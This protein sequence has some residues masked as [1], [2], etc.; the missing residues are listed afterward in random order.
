[1]SEEKGYKNDTSEEFKPTSGSSSENTSTISLS[2]YTTI[3]DY[4][5]PGWD[6]SEKK[7]EYW[8]GVYEKAKYEGRHRYDPSYKWT[9][10]EEKRLVRKIDLRIMLWAWIMFC[11]LDLNRR[12]IN[13]AITDNMLPELGMTTNDFNYG[14]TIFLASFLAAELPSGLIS[15]KLGPD[16]WIPFIIVAWSVVSASQGGIHSR[17]AYFACR[18]LMGLFMGGFVPD[19]VLYLT[20]FYKSR[21]LPIRLSWFWTGISTS[22][23]LGSFLAA[24][25]L[26]MRG[27][28][29]LSGWRYL[30][31]LEGCATGIIGL[32]SWGF[33][34][35]GPC[36]T[37]GNIMRNNRRGWF[38]EH[39]EYILVNRLLRDDPSKGDL[40]NRAAVG[41]SL[42]WKALKDYD[43][44]PV[45]LL[46][47]TAYVP[48]QPVA[49]YLSFILRQL[50][51]S[52]FEANLL[53]IPG[54]FLYAAQLVLITWVSERFDERSLIAS[55]S[56]WWIFPFLTA[57][58]ALKGTASLWVRYTLLTGIIGYPYCHAILAG[59][60]SRNSN[61]VR[62][63]TIS[64][65][66]YNMMVQSGNIIG[67]NIYRE[68]DKPLY[69]R[70]NK[71]LLAICC[72][73]I[74][75]FVLVKMYYVWRNKAREQK[76]ETLS[77][78][79]KE[80]YVAT[81]EHE[82]AKRWDFRFAH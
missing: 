64:A 32:L 55:I 42:F 63:R 14:Q 62:T 33:M 24:G 29:G 43:L 12:N 37:A 72:W 22:N 20:Y 74:V 49:S 58:V 70:G 54:Q 3:K 46:G 11:S 4:G 79:E 59:W 69:I 25:I 15:K 1:M 7:A 28:G 34:P 56:Q 77:E 57:L 9:A 16:R 8:R 19:I 80:D 47:L 61:S 40:H 2:E 73:N 35:P 17:S 71:I 10:A 27:I 36:Q 66:I 60:N 75:L 76:W 48:A 45:Y 52:T 26:Q 53:A 78:R 31:I 51:F 6:V 65:A 67:T 13:R 68:D 50:G 44:W 81:T 23:I 18:C 82:G 38:S 41:P 5:S 39:E 30:F 21:E